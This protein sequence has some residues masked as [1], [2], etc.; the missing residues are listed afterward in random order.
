MRVGVVLN[1]MALVPHASTEFRVGRDFFPDH[2]KLGPDISL[3][4]KVENGGGLARVRPVVDR[5]SEVWT[6]CLEIDFDWTE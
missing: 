1:R 2:V 4:E 5:K 6:A 3:L